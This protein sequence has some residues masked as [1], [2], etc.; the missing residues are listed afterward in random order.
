VLA[1]SSDPS[2][3]C[4]DR[5][6][7]AA[8]EKSNMSIDSEN[9]STLAAAAPATK[10]PHKA[11]KA[12]PAKKAGRANKKAEIITMMRRAKGAT[13]PEIMKATGWQAH[14]VRGFVSILGSKGGEKIESSKNAAGER[15]YKIGK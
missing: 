4:H 9:T 6:Q 5:N 2:D 13:L 12:K 10:G 8:K 1:L 11:K 7:L 3:E 14:T 15:T